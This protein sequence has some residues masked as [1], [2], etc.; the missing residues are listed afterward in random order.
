VILLLTSFQNVSLKEFHEHL[1]KRL[2]INIG[3]SPEMN[4]NEDCYNYTELLKVEINHKSKV[5]D[6]KL[7][8]S[9]PDWLVKDLQRQKDKK[10]LYVNKLDS[11]ALADG[12][13][14]CVL[15]FPLFL[16]SDD[17]PCGEGKKKRGYSE[18]YFKF[19]GKYLQGNIRFGEQIKLIFTTRFVSK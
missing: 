2:Q 13:K 1:A 18:N 8:D 11:I 4:G 10:Q 5:T 16:E 17:F 7:S 12:I 3:P 14:N 6:L 15:L 9:A 19:N